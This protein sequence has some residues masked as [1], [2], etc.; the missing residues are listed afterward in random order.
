MEQLWSDVRLAARV[1]AKSP[2]FTAVAVLSLAL[3]IGANATIFSLL[4]ALLLRPLPGRDP[5]RL[6]TVYTSDFSGPLF[7]Q[8]SYPDYLDFRSQS[9]AFDGLAAYAPQPLLLT[10]AGES[11][12]ALAQLV[13]GNFFDVVGLSAAYGRTL[14]PAEETPGQHPVA[15]LSDAVWRSRF[16]ADPGVVG[17]TIG[18]NGRPYSIVGIGPAGFAGMLRGVSVDVFVPLAMRATLTGESLA[19]RGNRG[20]MLIG[21]L[22]PGV[23]IEDARASLAVIARRLHASY[24]ERWSNRLGEPRVVSVLP[25]DAS[26]VLPQARGPLA[27]FLGVLFAAVGLLLLLACANVANL[28]LARAS[29]RRR[30]IAVRVALG[31][32]RGQLV[33]QLLAESLLLSCGAGVLG[34]ALAA[35]GVQ[36]IL[37]FQPPLPVSLALGLELDRRVLLFALALSIATGV[38]F[39]LWPALRASR[40]DPIQ[41]L[42]TRGADPHSRRRFAARDALVIVQVAGSLVLL[43]GAGLFLRSLSN[44]KAIDPGFDPAGVLVFSIDPGAQGYDD[45]RGARFYAELQERLAG[46]PGVESASF[47]SVLP[48]SLGGERRS[49]RVEGYAP[50]PGEDMELHSSFVGPGYF[51]TMRTAL[52]RGRGFTANDAPGAPGVVIVNEAFVRRY[53]PGRDGLGERVVAGDRTGDVPLEVVGVARDGKYTSLGEEPTPFVFY[54]H[55]QL[56]RAEMSVVVRAQGDPGALAPAVRREVA[57]LDPSLP[58]YDVKTLVAHLGTALFPARAAAALLGLTGALALLLAAIGLYGVLS[59]AVAL[60]TREIGVRVALGAERSDVL[61]LVVGRGLRLTGIGVAIGLALCLGV[62][63]FLSFLLY[64]ISP[65]DPLTFAAIPALL[66]SVALVAAWDPARRALRIDPAVSLREE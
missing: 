25:E 19:E 60:R 54:P 32:G 37:A 15:I 41:W 14:L 16:G 52:A 26:R 49:L 23:G 34:V 59:Y 64:G 7:A 21:R 6:V 56:H 58:V 35:V 46:L 36:L 66:A 30:E 4:N 8:S 2:G 13:S 44:A 47:A 50:G 42:T 29:A 33:R 3:G 27:G 28:L 9:Q 1:L 31:A 40:T 22:R 63:R 18:L 12:R 5:A 57:A 61:A 39:G 17:Q 62:T 65:L 55:R 20:L 45:A 10:H 51:E 48:L 11:R 53:W 24:G 43:I 38:V